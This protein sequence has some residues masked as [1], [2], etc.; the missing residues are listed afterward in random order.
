[1]NADPRVRSL[2]LAKDENGE[3][4][5]REIDH[6]WLLQ[7]FAEHERGGES[8]ESL[9]LGTSTRS[10][11]LVLVT[12][13]CVGTRTIDGWMHSFVRNPAR[14]PLLIPLV[15]YLRDNVWVRFVQFISVRSDFDL[16]YL[17]RISSKILKNNWICK[18]SGSV[19]RKCFPK[20]VEDPFLEYN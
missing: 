1:M 13:T 9:K 7:H 11:G 20:H 15:L 19:F 2:T 10:Q 8:P 5:R 3:R 6:P 12:D 18:H 17:E 4:A 16:E 14:R